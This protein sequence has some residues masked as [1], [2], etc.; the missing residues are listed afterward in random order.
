MLRYLF[1]KKEYKIKNA[2]K[3]VFKYFKDLQKH[4]NLSDAQ[5]I[6]LLRNCISEI[7]NNSVQKGFWLDF[8]KN[9]LK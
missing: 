9:F 6:T 8:Y 2:E 5:L 7:K 3:Y 4:F 1:T